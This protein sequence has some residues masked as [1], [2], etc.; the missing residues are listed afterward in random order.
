[1]AEEGAIL[2]RNLKAAVSG[3]LQDYGG[4]QQPVTDASAELHRLCGCLEQL[5]QF[6]QKEQKSFLRPRKDYWDFL[7]TALW[8]QRGGTEPVHFVHSQDK[9]KTPLAKGRALIRFCLAQGQLAESLQLCLLNTELTR[10]WYGPRSPLVCPELREDLLDALYTLNA[11]AFDLDLQWPNLDEAWPMFSESC[12]SSARTQGRRPRKTKDAPKQLPGTRYRNHEDTASDQKGESV[13]I[14]PVKR[15]D[16]DVHRRTREHREGCL[17]EISAAHGDPTGVQPEEPHT[18]HTGCQRDAP[19]EDWLAAPPRSQQHRHLRPSM[20]KKREDPRSLGPA[21]SMWEPE[22]EELQGAPRTGVCLENST[23][24]IQGQGERAKGAPK[25][26]IGTEAEDRGVLPGTEGTPKGGAEWGHV[27]RLLASSPAGTIE[28][29]MPGSRQELEVPSVLGDPRVLLRDLGAEED[30]APERPQGETGVTTVTRRK[31]QAAMALQD[32]VKSLRHGLQKTKEQAQHLEQLLKEREGELKTLQE[33]LSRCQEDRARL[34]TELE[35]K[36]QE[37]ERRDAKYEKELGGQRDL[38]R[39][40]K[41]RVL[42]LVREKDDLWQEVQ[43]LSSMAP[44]CCA[45]CSRVFGRLSRRYPCRLCGGLVCHA[46]SVDYKKRER[47][48][49]PCSQKGEAQSH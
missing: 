6:D 1:M 48:C 38:V 29:T 36:Q 39:A 19:R 8:R 24:S 15:G 42:E 34:Q 30:A 31:E 20:E 35:Q 33:Q 21:Q 44:G 7:C 49:P 46:C 17:R 4:R 47:R 13:T 16:A 22:G 40:M 43:R 27:H 5:L 3:I 26:V 45:A 18:S 28:D 2:T 11:V 14:Q 9:L 25:E 41:M 32:V 10:E 37:A 23:P 12:G